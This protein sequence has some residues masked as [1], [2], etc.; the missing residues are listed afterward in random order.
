MLL[1]SICLLDSLEISAIHRVSACATVM[2]VDRRL[3]IEQADDIHRQVATQ[4]SGI[5][6]AAYRGGMKADLGGKRGMCSK[7]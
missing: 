4:N 1:D 2:S 3:E 6:D 7:K 5:C